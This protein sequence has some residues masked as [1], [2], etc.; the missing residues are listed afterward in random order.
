M[1]VDS[2]NAS[3]LLGAIVL[4]ALGCGGCASQKTHIAMDAQR[5]PRPTTVTEFLA[6]PKPGSFE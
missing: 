1:I 3:R 5:E 2:F 4:L 6:Q